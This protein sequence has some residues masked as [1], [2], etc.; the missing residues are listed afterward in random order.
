MHAN[1][2]MFVEHMF[3]Y[4]IPYDISPIYRKG[5]GGK[6]EMCLYP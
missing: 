5:G 6:N 2:R 1:E 4:G 3:I